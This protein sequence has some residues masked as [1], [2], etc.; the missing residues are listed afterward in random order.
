MFAPVPP[1]ST[2]RC[3]G[4]LVFRCIR[5]HHRE[6]G[7][8]AT[9]LVAATG[10]EAQWRLSREALCDSDLLASPASRLE[11]TFRE[12]CAWLGRDYFGP[13]SCVLL[14]SSSHLR[15]IS[16][17]HARLPVIVVI[18]PLRFPA[19]LANRARHVQSW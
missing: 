14:L 19:R 4:W 3:D 7:G 13:A 1:R 10:K 12:G 9:I 18:P 2:G 15:R 17:A 16:F 11:G 8:D 6:R 5:E